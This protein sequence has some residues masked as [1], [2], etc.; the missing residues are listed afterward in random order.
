MASRHKCVAGRAKAQYR[1]PFLRPALFFRG[2]LPV[3][4]VELF[5]TDLWRQPALSDD[6]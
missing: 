4:S 6:A 5:C 2:L 1:A 3:L